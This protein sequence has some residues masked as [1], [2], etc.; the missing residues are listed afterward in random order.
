MDYKADA[1][2]RTNSMKKTKNEFKVEKDAG[3][4][5]VTYFEPQPGVNTSSFLAVTRDSGFKTI[6]K[7]LK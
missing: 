3:D 7:L 2:R 5:R 4:K 6:V 1:K